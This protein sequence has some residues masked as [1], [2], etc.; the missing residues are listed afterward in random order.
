MGA[1]VAKAFP[2]PGLPGNGLGSNAV[3]KMQA[4]ATQPN[5]RPMQPLQAMKPMTPSMGKS[6]QPGQAAFPV[7]Q[8]A[9]NPWGQN[10]G[11]SGLMPLYR[12]PGTLPGTQT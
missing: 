8:T 2:T 5:L 11:G 6:L 1:G 10:R 3:A 12:R 9:T 7:G 4:P